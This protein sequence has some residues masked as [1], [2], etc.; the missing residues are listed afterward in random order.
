M[1]NCQDP[2]QLVGF[3]QVVNDAERADTERPQPAQPAAQLMAGT[4]I[5]LEQREGFF[6]RVNQRPVERQQLKAS[7]AREDDRWHKSTRGAACGKL[8]PEVVEGDSLAIGNLSEACLDRRHC[9]AV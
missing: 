7:A 4:R 2:N 1:T 6:D 8:S 3:A 9:V 5:A